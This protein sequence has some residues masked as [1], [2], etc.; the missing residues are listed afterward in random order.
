M[1]A[2]NKPLAAWFLYSSL[3]I[4]FIILASKLRLM[5]YGD[6]VMFSQA[7]NNTSWLDYIVNRYKVWSGRIVIDA[8]MLPTITISAFWKTM[9]PLSVIFSSYFLWSITLKETVSRNIGVPLAIFAILLINAPVAGDAQWWATGFYNYLLPVTCALFLLNSFLT[10]SITKPLLWLSILLS[11]IA[12]SSEQVAIFLIICIP[13]IWTVNK[14]NR[15]SNKVL[16][17]GLIAVIL[18]TSITLLSPGSA[19]RFYG[20]AFRYMP[21]IIDM[22]IFQKA[23][24][25]VDRLIEHISLNRNICFIASVISLLAFIIKNGK[26]DWMNKACII[27]ATTCLIVCLTSLSPYMK[28]LRYITPLGKF[29]TL[30]FGS[31][32]V[33]GYY[34]FYLLV[35]ISMAAGS[36][37]NAKGERDYRGFIT[38]L[39]GCVV[40]IAIGLSP[41]AYASGERVL[42]VF[43]ITLIAYSLFN[44]KRILS[45]KKTIE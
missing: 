13:F 38:I 40:T 9:I 39:A 33:Y 15:V 22:S 10:P 43:N 12:T 32:R 21:Q 17:V 37:E 8:I 14:K 42:Y 18:G 26:N 23:M 20:E 1:N 25:G 7:L 41:T 11:F 44:L 19:S 6:D 4:L 31:L 36:I 24:I 30:D 28:D 34:F 5:P 35:L 2:N 16:S 29:Y 27:I 3:V 45:D